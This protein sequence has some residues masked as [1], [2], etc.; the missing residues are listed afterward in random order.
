MLEKYRTEENYGQ[1]ITK[2]NPEKSKRCKAQE[3]N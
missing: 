1:Y 3:K 2:H